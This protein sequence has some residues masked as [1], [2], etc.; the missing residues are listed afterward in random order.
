M[1][2]RAGGG[3]GDQLELLLSEAMDARSFGLA[4]VNLSGPGGAIA[5]GAITTVGARRYQVKFEGQTNVGAYHVVVG[6]QIMDL[7]GLAMATSYDASFQVVASANNWGEDAFTGSVVDSNRWQ[8]VVTN[9]AGSSA[10]VGLDGVGHLRMSASTWDSGYNMGRGY[11]S[12][13]GVM[14]ESPWVYYTAVRYEADVTG[15]SDLAL[16][17]RFEL[18]DGGHA[19]LKFD[20]VNGM[21]LRYGNQV[22][23]R[24]GSAL[25]EAQWYELKFGWDGTELRGWYR[26]RGRGRGWEGPTT[27]GCYSMRRAVRGRSG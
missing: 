6:P 5:P 7:A 17:Y 11:V 18:S 4:D 12:S 27:W 15:R 23:S 14:P 24:N 10:A 1:A 19:Y 26:E 2:E 25:Y 9:T 3:A 20:S 22:I 21:R 13:A 8:V 16:G